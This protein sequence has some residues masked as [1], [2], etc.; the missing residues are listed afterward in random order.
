MAHQAQQVRCCPHGADRGLIGTDRGLIG[1]DDV[2]IVTDTRLR[3]ADGQ[4]IDTDD[5]HIVTD[6]QLRSTDD[7]HIVTDARLRSADGQLIDTDDV[8]I[9]TDTQLRSADGQLIDTDDVH[10]VTDEG[11]LGTDHVAIFALWPLNATRNPVCRAAVLPS[12]TDGI[13]QGIDPELATTSPFHFSAARVA[14]GNCR[15]LGVA[16]SGPKSNRGRS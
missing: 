4:L 7:V 13:L 9:V 5:V 15:V 8:H 1:T 11:L 3:S 10:I 12:R 14:L 2:H 16:S 6:A